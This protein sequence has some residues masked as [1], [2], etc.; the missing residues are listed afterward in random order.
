MIRDWFLKL[1]V[2][3]MYFGGRLLSQLQLQVGQ[4]SYI[5][6]TRKLLMKI[7]SNE[8]QSYVCRSFCHAEKRNQRVIP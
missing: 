7:D 2:L 4:D 8:K 1:F 6:A 5:L 3:K